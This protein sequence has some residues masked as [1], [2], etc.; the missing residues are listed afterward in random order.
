MKNE[1]PQLKLKEKTLELYVVK[2][3]VQDTHDEFN[4]QQIPLD[5]F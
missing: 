5:F 3:T 4:R 1:E 2:V